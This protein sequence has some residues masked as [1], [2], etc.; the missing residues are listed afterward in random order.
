MSDKKLAIQ[1]KIDKA[2]SLITEVD[3]LIENHF[4]TTA[5][6]RLYYSCFHATKALLLTK[7]LTS[8]T[9]SGTIK[10]LSQH[11]VA[12]GEFEKQQAVFFAKLMKERIDED[13]NDFIIHDFSVIQPY[14]LA[15][16]EYLDYTLSLTISFLSNK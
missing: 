15:A 1:L 7:D 14:L 2:K 12:T 4:Y 16:R 5:V 3:I 6:S 8:K 11:F 9:H 10:L 13:Y